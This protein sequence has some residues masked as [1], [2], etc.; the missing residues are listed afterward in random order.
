MPIPWCQRPVQTKKQNE[1]Y[2][3]EYTATVSP[4]YSRTC[5]SAPG[6]TCSLAKRQAGYFDEEKCPSISQDLL[7]N[8]ENTEDYT[9]L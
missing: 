6:T 8:V 4:S 9:E 7:T 2:T 3:P 1:T 5:Y